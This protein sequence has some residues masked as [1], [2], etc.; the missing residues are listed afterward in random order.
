ML[1]TD[2]RIAQASVQGVAD[3]L[4]GQLVVAVLQLYDEALALNVHEIATLCRERLE[5]YKVP[6]RVWVCKNW[7]FT[8]SGK[9]DHA[10][11]STFIQKG[12]PCLRALL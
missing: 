3:P 4:R 6:K 10:A 5:P 11:L 7:P 9:T 8:A 12:H 1:L 2:A